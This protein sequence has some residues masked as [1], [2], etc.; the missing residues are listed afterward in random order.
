MMNEKRVMRME[1]IKEWA[2]MW[3]LSM[4]EAV[5]ELIFSFYENAGFQTDVLANE[6]STKSEAELI[7]MFCAI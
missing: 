2:E 5:Y 3:G 4:K 1:E 6:L 7:E